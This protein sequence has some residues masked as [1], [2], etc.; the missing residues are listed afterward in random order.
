MYAF[1][2]IYTFHYTIWTHDN[3]PAV[4]KKYTK[5]IKDNYGCVRKK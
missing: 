4:P 2:I 1:L 5:L 3:S